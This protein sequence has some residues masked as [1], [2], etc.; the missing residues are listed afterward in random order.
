MAMGYDDSV[1]RILEVGSQGLLTRP[2]ALYELL[3]GMV[4]K[5]GELEGLKLRIGATED[6]QTAQNEQLNNA[7]RA[8]NLLYKNSSA[9]PAAAA[10]A[11]AS[12]AT[13]NS[14]VTHNTTQLNNALSE[15]I[16]TATDRI[17]RLDRLHD[18]MSERMNINQA[19]LEKIKTLDEIVLGRQ[20]EGKG[21][22]ETISQHGQAIFQMEQRV[23][24]VI[25]NVFQV[26]EKLED[27][28]L[29]VI[30]AQCELHAEPL[31]R[32]LKHVEKKLVTALSSVATKVSD[33]SYEIDR[34]R[35]EEEGVV[36]GRMK[37]IE[38]TLGALQRGVDGKAD[39]TDLSR[40]RDE[41]TTKCDTSA[42]DVASLYKIFD[43]NRRDVAWAVEGGN[44][45]DKMQVLH[46]LPCFA[47][48]A[49][50]VSRV[51]QGGGG[52]GASALPNYPQHPQ[53]GLVRPPSPSPPAS[54]HGGNRTFEV[55]PAHPSVAGFEEKAFPVVGLEIVDGPGPGTGVRVVS[56]LSN[57]PAA[58]AGLH[59]GDRI[60][61]F[62]GLPT[63][64][65]ASFM[66]GAMRCAPGSRAAVVRVTPAAPSFPEQ[67]ELHLG[68]VPH[69]SSGVNE[70]RRRS[71]GG[72]GLDYSATATPT[73]A[74]QAQ[75]RGSPPSSPW[76]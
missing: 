46:A 47:G 22:A 1:K 55:M 29:G 76:R 57:S 44:P 13:H 32:E 24:G 35:A 11:P 23:D 2:D 56:V 39:H 12:S 43:L 40:L 70:L 16:T 51:G 72:G 4:S 49:L 69:G 71:Y 74:S 10:S 41:V 73:P 64:T 48:L 67:M 19:L 52:G 28:R 38:H 37:E 63:D 15:Q 7:K 21:M 53:Y 45:A 58:R 36:H 5:M 59:T 3:V 50:A 14:V 9:E 6:T 34:L 60:L 61:A 33:S 31:R 66:E 20:H 42:D 65:R 18:I 68:G 27:S 25:E 54:P 8:I 26:A 62:N 75:G 17:D 30:E